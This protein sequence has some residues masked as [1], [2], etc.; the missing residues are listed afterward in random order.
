MSNV[1]QCQVRQEKLAALA[2][3]G[4]IYPNH[5]KPTHVF[6]EVLAE[7]P[8]PEEIV[9]GRIYEVCGRIMTS[10]VMG[11]AAFFTLQ[12]RSGQLQIYIRMNDVGEAT[13]SQ[14]KDWDLGDIIYAK[15]HAF[16]TKMGELTLWVS[17]TTLLVKALRPLPDKFH[18]LVDQE[19]KYRQRYL[20][21]IANEDSRSVFK[22]RIKLI[23]I[24]RDFCI[25]YDEE[26]II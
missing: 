14:V 3:A 7:N 12:D 15:G 5:L 25:R 22:K 11:K 23:Q 9:E 19:V 26:Y 16:Y 13:F 20:D 1:D 8:S 2:E 4:P 6:S 21:L 10:R 24:I 18:G 17:D